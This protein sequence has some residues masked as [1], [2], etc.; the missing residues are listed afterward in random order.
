V[1]THTVAHDV[2]APSTTVVVASPLTSDVAAPRGDELASRVASLVASALG[3]GA[4]AAPHPM[5][6]AA[7]RALSAKAGALLY[8]DVRVA[9][10]ELRLTADL[11]PVV[12]NAWDR[13]RAPSPPPSKHSYV[14]VRVAAEVR[15]YLAPIHLER[16]HLTKFT[17]DVGPVLALACGDVE[18]GT[19]NAL[20]LVSEREVA[21]GHLAGG[22]F[23][24]TR[25]VPAASVG[26]RAAIPMREPMASA[27]IAGQDDGGLLYVGWTGRVGA[28]LGSDLA[29]RSHLAGLPASVGDKVVCLAPSSPKGAF[30]AL[31]ECKDGRTAIADPISPAPLFDAWSTADISGPDGV[32]TRVVAAR[33]PLSSLHLARGRDS[34][35]VSNVGAQ[36]A[37][38]DL[39]QD[40]VVE[41][42]T[43]S[44]TGDDAIVVSSW[45]AAGLVQ[46]L[47]FAAPRGV[48]A[49]AVCPAE[50]NDAPALVAA[51]G[52]EIWLVR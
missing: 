20:A 12:A 22:R 32:V 33:D 7:A 13:V 8:I 36:L 10:G 43:T 6:L 44:A 51:V 18:G 3:P 11:Y 42:V 21:W 25:R 14:H 41:V 9:E 38:G 48:D 23:V 40:G 39:D 27:A 28:T 34:L 26:L 24:A 16:A 35:T 5:S 49:L 46:R 1:A 37:L 17:H 30:E 4:R 31:V 45:R 19:G 15:S 52:Q 29:P 47:R 2:D 50:V